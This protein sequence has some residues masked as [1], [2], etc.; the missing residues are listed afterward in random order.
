M[1][2]LSPFTDSWGFLLSGLQ[3][4]YVNKNHKYHT[5]GSKQ[6]LSDIKQLKVPEAS[7][8]IVL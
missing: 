5:A 1:T 6:G 8:M 2:F 3:I 4:Y 7:V